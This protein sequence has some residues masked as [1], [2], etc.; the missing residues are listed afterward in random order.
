[1]TT[2]AGGARG[3]ADG[4]G[5]A[6][7][8]DAPSALTIDRAGTLFLA[9]TGN[10]AIRRITPDGTVTT[11][12]GGGGAGYRDGSGRD[13]QFNGPI[14]IA[15]DGTGRLLVA[16]TYNDRIR[17]I[18][19]DGVVTTVA[20]GGVPGFVDGQGATA[21]FDSP[22][23]IAVDAAGTIF[24]ADTGNDAVRRIDPSGSVTTVPFS[25]SDGLSRPVAVAAGPGRDIYVTEGRGR[26]IAMAPDGMTRTLA[27]ASSGFGDGPGAEARFRAPSAVA[28]AAPGRL[29]VADTGNALVRAVAAPARLPLLP[30]ASARVHP[31]FDVEA[32][33]EHSL[34]WPV[35]PMDVP[36]EIAGTLGEARG[37]EGAE[38]FHAG[39]DVREDEGTPVLAVRAGWV[40]SPLAAHDFGTL[41]ESLRVGALAYVHIRAGRDRHNVLIDPARFVATYDA[42]GTMTRVRIKRGA[43]FDVGEAIGTVNAFNHVHLNVG[44][45]GEE[46]NPLLFDLIGFAD[47]IPP[48]IAKGGIRLL[49]ELGQPLKRRVRG[50]V[51][52]SGRVQVVVDAWDQ[53][54]GNR[55][56]RRLGLYDLGYQILK[57]DGTPLPGFESVRHTL[58]FDRLASDPLAATL[59]YA[60]GSGIPFYRGRR[61]R[62]LYMVTNRLNGGIAAPDVWDTTVLPAGDYIVRAWAADVRGNVA[63]ANRDLP[64]T[65]VA[66]EPR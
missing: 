7:R 37:T 16:D 49:D 34:L 44:W 62:F 21:Y 41:N 47:T 53:T 51:V 58:R 61:T 59:A 26:I 63:L 2:L 57:R 30:P 9:D 15:V 33:R 66:A 6:A 40:S 25:S 38:R 23:G 52:V 28:V 36:H 18:T 4:Q 27:G 8:F 39:I 64:V 42:D 65:I 55:P 56:N 5:T 31:R 13:A 20:G 54:D 3:L 24:V 19:P 11:V 22:S 32:F 43:T 48:S 12:A 14:G 1:V 29:I 46:H 10:N 60:P 35:A 17:S 50:R 45:S